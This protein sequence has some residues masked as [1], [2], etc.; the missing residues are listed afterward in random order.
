MISDSE[1]QSAVGKPVIRLWLILAVN[2]RAATGVSDNWWSQNMLPKAS[3]LN[4]IGSLLHCKEVKALFPNMNSRLGFLWRKKKMSLSSACVSSFL[5]IFFCP[6][7]T[8]ATDCKGIDNHLL[9]TYF[10]PLPLHPRPPNLCLLSL[11]LILV[12]ALVER[13]CRCYWCPSCPCPS[14]CASSAVFLC[15]IA[16]FSS[17][18][19]V[20]SLTT[21][22]PW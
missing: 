20:G 22:I 16:L 10:L 19:R 5:L 9:F 11:F 13:C 7:I 17:D 2:S 15:V 3:T 1:R 12:Y 4:K 21:D 8:V 6:E 14:P 18:K